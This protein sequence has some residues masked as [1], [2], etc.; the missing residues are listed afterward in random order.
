MNNLCT[1]FGVLTIAFHALD[2]PSIQAYRLLAACIGSQCTCLHLKQLPPIWAT[3]HILRSSPQNCPK[4]CQMTCPN[5]THCSTN[6][7]SNLTTCSQDLT[8]GPFC[9][10]LTTLSWTPQHAHI[11]N[12][13]LHPIPMSSNHPQP[14]HGNPTPNS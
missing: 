8:L 4:L 3:F 1:H 6:F 7:Q 2:H 13:H 10:D 9:H 11:I 5:S 14:L 12:N